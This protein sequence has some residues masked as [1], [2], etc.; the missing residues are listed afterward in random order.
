[1][2]RVRAGAKSRA[3][4]RVRVTVSFSVRAGAE[5][6]PSDSVRVWLGPGLDLGLG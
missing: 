3:S 6:R 2:F 4:V 1:M 5:S